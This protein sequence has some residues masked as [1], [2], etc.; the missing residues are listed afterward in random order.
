MVDIPTNRVGLTKKDY[1]GYATTLCSGCGHNSITAG[2]IESCYDMGIRPHE[3]VKTS[4]IGC[5]SKSP[6]YF[7]NR[8]HGFNGF[9][10]RAPSVTAGI[11]LAD[12]RLKMLLVS[13]DG[14]SSNI[15][16]GQFIHAIR[17]NT[18][19]LYIIENNGTYGLTKGQFSATSDQNSPDHYGEVNPYTPIDL[20]QLAVEMGASFVG[21]SF[22]GDKKQMVALIKAGLAHKGCAVLDILSPCVTFMNHETSPKSFS[23]IKDHD[24][25]LQE[26]GFVPFFEEIKVDYAPG[27]AKEV[28]L[29]DGSHLILK[30]LQEDYDPTSRSAALA[31]IEKGLL[32]KNVVTG[33]IYY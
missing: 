25:P 15:G 33:L 26:L 28:T 10:G 20:A 19:M 2:I 12:Q 3:I 8:S 13:G 30:K 11:K 14:D 7:L 9:H 32:E 5:S 23:Y 18:D 16:I 4:G 29:H 27:E 1:S 21:R 6:T 22:S 17:R 31:V 24:I